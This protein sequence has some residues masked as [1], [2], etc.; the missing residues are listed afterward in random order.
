MNLRHC[1]IYKMLCVQG[2]QIWD[3]NKRKFK[4]LSTKKDLLNKDYKNNNSS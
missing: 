3:T 2:N 1:E 4:Y